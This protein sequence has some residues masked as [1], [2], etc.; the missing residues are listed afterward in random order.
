MKTIIPLFLVLFVFVCYV[1]GQQVRRLYVRSAPLLDVMTSIQMQTSYSFSLPY[2]WQKDAKPVTV[3]LKNADLS[4]VL[5]VIFTNQPFYAKVQDSSIFVHRRVATDSVPVKVTADS[6]HTIS[7]TG[8]ISDQEEQPIVG[9]TVQVA[10]YP[11][12]GAVTNNRGYF[13]IDNV[14]HKGELNISYI[15][16][17]NQTIPY[18][19][20]KT[21]RINLTPA[22]TL[23]NDVISKG[24]Y[25]TS[26]ELNTGSVGLV[27]GELLLRHPVAD[28]FAALSG[29][30]PGL[31]VM[32][33]SGL[34]G[35]VLDIIVRGRNSLINGT[36]PLII[37]DNLPQTDLPV[38]QTINAA[39]GFSPTAG[40]PT[41]FIDRIEVL[42]DADA[43]AIYG[44]RGANGVI[45]ITTKKNLPDSTRYHFDIYQGIGKVAKHL[46]FLDASQF[47][48]MRR[49]ALRNDGSIVKDTD[50]DLKGIWDTTATRNLQDQL[51]GGV[52]K[53]TNVYAGMTGGLERTR[54]SLD[55][56]FHRESTVYPGSYEITNRALRGYLSHAS[57][58]KK[59]TMQL[60]ANFSFTSNDLPQNDPAK[61][62]NGAPFN[63]P[64]YDAKGNLN[65]MD[66]KYWNPVSTLHQLSNTTI[67][68]LRGS[69]LMNY[70]L[71]QN[72]K[73]KC[74]FGYNTTLLDETAIT[75]YGSVM[76][77]DTLQA[78]QRMYKTGLNNIQSWIA[79]PQVSYHL[80]KGNHQFD[81]LLGATIQ[82]V[83]NKQT[84][85]SASGF[86]SDDLI[87]DLAMADTVTIH[88]ATS[89]YNYQGGFARLGYNLQNRYIFNFTG[90]IDG[91][92]KFTPD[93]RWGKFWAMGAA[94]IFSKEPF[95]AGLDSILT[96]G[97]VRGS[98]GFI[99]SDQL[100]YDAFRVSYIPTTGYG[101]AKGYRPRQLASEA[102]GWET[103]QKL[104][105]ALEMCF[106]E[107]FFLQASLYRNKTR[108]QLV[109]IPLSVI[110]GATEVLGNV[111]VQ[112]EN[113]GLELF[114]QLDNIKRTN[115]NWNTS[116]TLTVPKN[117]LVKYPGLEGS[118]YR[119]RFSVG[120]S[121]N[122]KNL[123]S[124]NGVDSS[125][126]I[127]KFVQLDANPSL[128]Q[129]DKRPF[130]FDPV[131]YGNLTN[132]VSFGG[133]SISVDLQYVKQPGYD[134]SR[135][136]TAG[137]LLLSGSNQFTSILNR[138]QQ[139]GNLAPNQQYS[140]TNMDALN[141]T[142]YLNQ[143][144][145]VHVDASYIRLK[146]VY[147]SYTLPVFSK[148]L[149]GLQQ[150]TLYA[151]AENLLTITRFKGLDPE[152]QRFGITPY[153]P[154]LRIFSTGL[155]ITL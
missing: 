52:A 38:T 147:L 36:A 145:A 9:A 121:I 71:S 150:L 110:T 6:S 10:G 79:E 97:K 124:Y 37:I 17:N 26:P 117:K 64:F 82:K 61:N 12:K 83:T 106:F 66:G 153:L 16:Y 146:N 77:R 58:D 33:T 143:S 155:R 154:P 98:F 84:F 96:L 46:P 138:W 128:D 87:D 114:I 149:F 73:L 23:L 24:Y 51:I 50:Y 2:D 107:K 115:F 75:P 93:K 122:S 19:G 152:T 8:I 85:M 105:I 133:F 35:A 113:K 108:N 48:M 109:V 112:V 70:N 144:D 90:R 56:V 141:A 151:N 127:Y 25:S 39:G 14:R 27:K 28:P 80:N 81:A 99:G 4:S 49:E 34:A 104:E 3:K 57:E 125:T 132:T 59:F 15:G 129:H 139:P 55:G 91:S 88:L 137:N 67:T 72:F 103:M 69:M 62:I 32:Q 31:F 148:K 53:I 116:F 18:Y 118:K 42:R 47:L 30:V 45:L 11:K 135:A 140:A 43:T 65:W 22:N 76:P 63:V 74:T 1:Q 78:E 54:F 123:F 13:V 95:M 7:I 134:N 20:V 68:Y 130:S 21:L 126:G 136:V 101:G 86:P 120:A 29:K 131:Y 94:W 40:L 60:D 102:S 44:S 111:P 92:S 100:P 142:S 89:K 119:D 5:E 41:A